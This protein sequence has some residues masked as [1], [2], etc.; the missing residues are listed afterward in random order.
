MLILFA[1]REQNLFMMLHT[2]SNW[3]KFSFWPHLFCRD[4]PHSQKPKANFGSIWIGFWSEKSE[5]FFLG[6]V[7]VRW[8]VREDVRPIVRKVKRFLDWKPNAH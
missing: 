2:E 6:S 1:S 7:K 3:P 4:C 5:F 8:F